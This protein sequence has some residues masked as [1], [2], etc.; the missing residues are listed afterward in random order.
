MTSKYSRVGQTKCLLI[1]PVNKDAPGNEVPVL[2]PEEL[3]KL[4]VS[5][6]LKEASLDYFVDTKSLFQ[7]YPKKLWSNLNINCTVSI[8][9]ICSNTSDDTLKITT[10]R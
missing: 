5:D 9:S 10:V 1:I 3:T 8:S 2:I 4:N 6:A 7:Y